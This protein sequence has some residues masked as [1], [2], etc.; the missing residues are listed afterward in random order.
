MTSLPAGTFNLTVRGRGFAPLTVPGLAIPE[1]KGRTDLGTVSLA[2]GVPLRGLVT[3]PK[4][5]P[6][7]GAEVRA[8]AA[9]R[10]DRMPMRREEET[11]PPDA[12]TTGDGSFVL[13]DRA[14]GESLDLNV[15]HPD[16]GPGRAPGVA[17]PAETPV[18]VVLQRTVR[19][20][21][22]VSGPD[23]KPVAGVQVSLDELTPMSFGSGR[24]TLFPAGRPQ[25]AATDDEGGF[26]FERV[27]PGPIELRAEAPRYQVAKLEG[28]EASPGQELA[29]LEIVLLPGGVVEGR[30]LSPDGRPLPGAEVILSLTSER[31]MAFTPHRTQ[32]DGDGRYRLDGLPT[33]P[34]TLEARAEGYRRAAREVE[35]SAEPKAVDFQLERGLE[36]SGRVVNEA[37]EPVAGAD[38]HLVAGINQFDALRVQSGS[39]GAFRIAGVQDGSYRLRVRKEGYATDLQGHPVTVSGASVGDIELKL[40]SGGR[41]TGRLSGLEFSDLARVRVWAGYELNQGRVDSEGVYEI[42]SLAPMEWEITAVVPNT[43]LRASG[44]VTLEPGAREA[45]L[46]LQFGDGRELRG[47]VLRNGQPLPGASVELDGTGN[48]E[49]AAETTDH[50]GAFRFG[51]LKDGVYDLRVSTPNGAQHKES[52]EIAGN[53]DIRVELRTASLSGRV[54]DSQD[55]SPISGARVTLEPVGDERFFFPPLETDAKGT[56]RLLEVGGGAWKVKAVRDGYAP[57]EREIQVDGSAPEEIELTLQPT[58][59]VTIEALLTSGQ[60]PDRIQVAALDPQGN[61]VVAGN[62]PTGENGR[63]R[64]SNVP[65]GSW[66]L[67]VQSDLSAAVAVS[68][69]V[70]GPAVRVILPSSGRLQVKVPALAN[71]RTAK[72]VLSGAGG[73]FRAIDFDGKAT[74]EWNL[75]EGQVGFTRVPVGV[76]QVTV[77]TPDGRSWNGTATVTAGGSAEVTLE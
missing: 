4:G 41:I 8:S 30:V 42:S 6:I 19:V 71:D 55:H 7:A 72:V 27:A 44:R 15:T 39:D 20:S 47:V 54:I 65:P 24:P 14:S 52:V 60:A 9:E 18:R 57:A 35:V 56:F 68:V 50:Q 69:S 45:R 22:K 10:N 74:S 43:S 37:G 62:Y 16:Y 31:G 33:G 21:G 23:G 77:R 61:T 3:D 51:G 11:G 29:G 32:S 40:S 75:R 70:P 63:T 38:V 12:T 64:L 17:V 5:N 13:E 58:E 66:E 76:W 73:V 2:P 26:A 28:L 53:R 1:G 59:G 36:V 25:R 49:A 34:Q 48:R 67:L 46:D